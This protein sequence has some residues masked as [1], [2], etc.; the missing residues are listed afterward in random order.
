MG[1]ADVGSTVD[2]STDHV[3]TAQPAQPE[4][5][6]VEPVIET[7]APLDAEPSAQVAVPGVAAA[8]SLAVPE[9][10][11]PRTMAQ[12]AGATCEPSADHLPA[13]QMLQTMLVCSIFVV[14]AAQIVQPVNVVPLPV[15]EGLVPPYPASQVSTPALSAT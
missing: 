4:Y 14:P 12:L 8:Y 15:Y 11:A 9:P 2:A 6:G 5:V 13:L 7:E 10:A 3:P 1:H